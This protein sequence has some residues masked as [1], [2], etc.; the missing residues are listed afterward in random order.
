MACDRLDN[1]NATTRRGILYTVYTHTLHTLT[2]LY[3]IQRFLHCVSIFVEIN[4]LIHFNNQQWALLD[5]PY[6][7]AR[8]IGRVQEDVVAVVIDMRHCRATGGTAR[9][10]THYIL[11]PRVT[12]YVTHFKMFGILTDVRAQSRKRLEV[13]QNAE[14][15]NVIILQ[16]RRRHRAFFRDQQSLQHSF[17]RLHW[18]W[19]VYM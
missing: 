1:T 9:M 17:L 6:H 5:A 11:L 4:S 3:R 10:V 2:L 14:L 8:V 16:G 12:H 15:V 19:S 13:G 18:V 7:Q